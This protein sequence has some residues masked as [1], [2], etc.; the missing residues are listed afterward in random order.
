MTCTWSLKGLLKSGR[1]EER[2]GSGW[3]LAFRLAWL[4]VREWYSLLRSGGEEGGDCRKGSSVSR[5]EFQVP[6][7]RGDGAVRA[8]VEYKSSI[9]GRCQDW[10]FIVGDHQ[11]KD[12]SKAMSVDE[13][14][15]GGELEKSTQSCTLGHSRFR[16]RKK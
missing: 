15:R 6:L 9:P 4:G 10:R 11:K 5:V 7:R 2:E 1:D 3:L 16:D 14:T 8:A 13:V 12:G